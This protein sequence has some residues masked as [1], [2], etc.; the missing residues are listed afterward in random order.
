[1][2]KFRPTLES[3][4]AT[5]V[6]AGLVAGSGI[7]RAQATNTP[8]APAPS[9]STAQAPKQPH[10]P[11]V[12]PANFTATSPSK[13]AVESFL[14]A[15]W[16]YDPNRMYEI[17]AIL[18]TPAPGV[19]KV[20]VFVAEKD[21][22]QVGTVQFFVTPDG[23]HLIAGESILPFGADPFA[24]ARAL[25]QKDANGPWMGSASRTHELVEFADLECPHC[26]EAQ[27]TMEKLRA[28]FPKARFVFENFPLFEIHP[29]AFL[30]AAYGECVAK[31][32]GN[33]AFFKY[34]DD[35]FTNQDKLTPADGKTTLAAAV[36]AAG[37]DPARIAACANSP[38]GKAA[39]QASIDLGQKLHVDETPTLYV[40]GRP[41]P[42]GAMP[43]SALRQLVEYQFSM[44]KASTMAAR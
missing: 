35:V 19:T 15:S 43:Y 18:K 20:V 4:L 17:A 31:A 7:A 8:A 34:V 36:T 12:N 23:Q 16:G 28:D 2:M 9:A 37:Q 25:L 21:H 5:C 3:M 32:G 30:A 14:K 27:S 42:V 41:V 39:V 29:E 22:P 13:A 24:Q 10:L 26:K 40:D 38:A 11:P 6:V 44:D 33:A 1:M